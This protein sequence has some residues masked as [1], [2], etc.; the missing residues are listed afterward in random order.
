MII[1]LPF[2]LPLFQTFLFVLGLYHKSVHKLNQFYIVTCWAIY[3]G[4]WP[5]AGYPCGTT[6]ASVCIKTTPGCAPGYMC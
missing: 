6:P 5:I 4:C 3:T 2:K 1:V